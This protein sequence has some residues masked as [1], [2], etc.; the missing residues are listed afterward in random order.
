MLGAIVG[1]VLRA[2]ACIALN[3]IHY[4][5]TVRCGGRSPL[6]DI[7]A[8]ALFVPTVFTL[9]LS[10]TGRPLHGAPLTVLDL[11]CAL[12]SIFEG[13]AIGKMIPLRFGAHPASGPIARS[14]K[15]VAARAALDE[16]PVVTAHRSRVPTGD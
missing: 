12:L 13:T 7:V 5:N 11:M 6:V 15:R 4:G 3:R 2:L 9:N 16:R 8:A 14:R 10:Y 1:I